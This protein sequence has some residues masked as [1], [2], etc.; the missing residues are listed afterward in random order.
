MDSNLV[1][2]RSAVIASH[3]ASATPHLLPSH[4]SG[5]YPQGL[6]AGQVAIITGSGQ[7]IGAKCAELFAKEGAKVVVTD[8][9]AA[10][11]DAVA[12]SIVSQGGVATSFPGDV[13]HA[14]FADN[15][16][17]HTI[18]TFSK[19][20][21][22]VNNAGYTWDGVLHKMTDK[23]WA[24][25]LDCHNTAPFRLIRAASPYLREPA[26]DEIDKGLPRQ[27]RC[28]VNISSISG[29][30]GNAGQAN[31]STAKMGIVGLTKTVAKEWGFLGIRCN[32]VAFGH[33]TTR[34][35]ATQ[36]KESV[37]E[38]EGE[39]VRL[40]IPAAAQSEALFKAMVPFG[41]PGTVD[42]AAGAVLMLCSP[43]ASYITGQTI[44]VTGG[45]SL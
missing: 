22:I 15:I 34:L 36:T 1:N 3:L 19:I 11:S 29:T 37:I 14:D 6:L 43:F 24:A 8:I 2:R 28:I 35:T 4:C 5:L 17:K 16:V 41:R 25:I 42:E 13:T 30:H 39:K 9:D 32:A 27:P 12:A 18:K 38:V 26:K 44:E 31:Y 33:I 40:G 20:N 23:Q 45:G 21:I 10:K 7:G